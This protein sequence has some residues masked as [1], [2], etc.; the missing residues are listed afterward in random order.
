LSRR[1]DK[2]KDSD[3]SKLLENEMI[4]KGIGRS[5]T[6]DINLPL[7]AT[8]RHKMVGVKD[9]LKTVKKMTE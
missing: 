6:M 5:A 9:I 4:L 2:D 7:S 1:S 3:T 8:D